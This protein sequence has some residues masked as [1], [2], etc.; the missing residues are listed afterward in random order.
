MLIFFFVTI[1]GFWRF[2]IRLNSDTFLLR[3]FT[4]S[5]LHSDFL[6]N[7]IHNSAKSPMRI[8]NVVNVF[9]KRVSSTAFILPPTRLPALEMNRGSLYHRKHRQLTEQ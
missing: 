9:V 5:S 2:P 7:S 4:F 6:L 8:F 1:I 3:Y